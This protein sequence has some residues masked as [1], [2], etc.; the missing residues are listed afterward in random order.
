ME[1]TR[2][3]I[4]KKSQEPIIMGSLLAPNKKT[5]KGFDPAGGLGTLK[6]CIAAIANAYAIAILHHSVLTK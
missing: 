5:I 6:V 4:H 1:P 2:V 3:G